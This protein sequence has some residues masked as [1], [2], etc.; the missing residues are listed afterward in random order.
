M[1]DREIFRIKIQAHYPRGPASTTWTT[2]ISKQPPVEEIHQQVYYEKL[3]I[4]WIYYD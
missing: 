2:T 4:V 3:V 1:G